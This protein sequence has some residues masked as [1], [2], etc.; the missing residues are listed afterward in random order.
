MELALIGVTAVWG[1][2]FPLVK[3]S[4]ERCERVR[5]GFGLESA[6]PVDPFL[7]LA[8]RFAIAAIALAAIGARLPRSMIKPALWLGVALFAG[9]ATQTLGLQR[10][11]ASN[12]AFITGLYV[13]M[14]PLMTAVV[15]RRR[16]AAT[17]VIGAIV[18]TI[19]LFLMASPTG[20][21][22]GAGEILVLGTA[23][24]FAVHI[25]GTGLVAERVSPMD[26]VLVQ[27][28]V[29][30]AASLAA[31]FIGGDAALPRDG[32]IW[33]AAILTGVLASA[34]AFALQTRAQ[35]RIPASR[36]AVILTAESVFGGLFGFLMLSER[37]GPRGY[38]GAVL[39][40]AGILIAEA[41]VRDRGAT[42]S[43]AP[44]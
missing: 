30:A 29:A 12:V 9:Y 1:L 5:G 4:V 11:S 19:G 35:K 40:T 39:I 32:S 7:F 22:L 37:L 16:P 2:T 6:A 28:I 17:T 34:V 38:A 10:T 43:A 27:S 36:T 14:V 41:L 24:S 21:G 13:L 3:C 25:F 42:A 23:A 8:L 33:A 18:A 26:F 15:A 44:Q 20:L 31:A